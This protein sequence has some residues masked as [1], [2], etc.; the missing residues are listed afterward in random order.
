M[1]VLWGL[2]ACWRP[3][4]WSPPPPPPEAL[5]AMGIG[6][7]YEPGAEAGAEP[8]EDGP[9]RA[10]ATASADGTVPEPEEAPAPVAFDPYAARITAVPATIVDDAGTPLFVVVALGTEVEVRGEDLPLRRRVRCARCTPVTEGW[11]QAGIVEP[12]PR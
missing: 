2:I 10:Y 5:E 12:L 8:E 7:T 9:G 11:L 3:G 1:L 4:P 6:A